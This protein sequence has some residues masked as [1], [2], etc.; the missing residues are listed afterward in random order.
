MKVAETRG[1]VEGAKS[2]EGPGLLH[3]RQREAA[4]GCLDRM[5]AAALE[6]GQEQLE[7]SEE[8]FEKSNINGKNDKRLDVR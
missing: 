7:T 1:G 2:P 8:M 5:E 3:R 6:W 4:T